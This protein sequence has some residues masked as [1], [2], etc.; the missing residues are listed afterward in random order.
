MFQLIVVVLCGCLRYGMVYS[1]LLVLIVPLPLPTGTS[2]RTISYLVPVCFLPSRCIFVPA[3]F[4]T[5]G[6]DFR[7][8]IYSSIV[9]TYI[10]IISII[11]GR[12]Q[13][14]AEPV[15]VS[16]IIS[17]TWTR[18][19]FMCAISSAS[20]RVSFV[21]L[22]AKRRASQPI[23]Y[24]QMFLRIFLIRGTI[25]NRTYGTHKNRICSTIFTNN[26]WSCQLWPPVIGLY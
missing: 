21:F 25:V 17:C 26:I 12:V 2:V 5:T 18:T 23:F 24:F 20:S 19:H 10:I 8:V 14:A 4:V 15:V 6:G 1:S 11:I 9:S 13:T 16:G 3:C 22:G 7:G